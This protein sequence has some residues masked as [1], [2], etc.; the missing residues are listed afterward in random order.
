MRERTNYGLNE[1]VQHFGRNYEIAKEIWKSLAEE[2]V[3]EGFAPK[4]EDDLLE[5]FGLADED[6]DDLVLGI[7]TRCG[8]R[9]PPPSET[10]DMPPVRTVTDLFEFVEQMQKP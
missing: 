4:P 10:A 5:V 2:A 6:L 9:I 7:L 8:C 1:F 3:V